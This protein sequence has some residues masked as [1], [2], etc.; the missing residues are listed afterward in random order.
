MRHLKRRATA[1]IGQLGEPDGAIGCDLDLNA[2]MAALRVLP[3]G[4][5]TERDLLTWIE[6]PLRGFFVFER[7]WGAYGNLSGR[8]IQRRSLISSGHDPEFLATCPA[9]F[10]LQSRSCFAWWVFHR[11]ALVLDTTG[12]QDET[13]ARVVATGCELD[14]IERFSLGV[15]AAHGVI[16]PF[17]STGTYF[18]FSG[19]PRTRPK[20]TLAALNLIAPVLHNL[21]LQTRQTTVST[22][23]LAA[24][25]DRQRELIDLAM[26]GLSDKDI[27]LRIGISHNT[28]GNH[29]SSIYAKLG[30]CKRGQLIALS[31]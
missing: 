24:L 11:K 21:Y 3:N 20:R 25:T 10:D 27:A 31:K 6:G 7:F 5:L 26:Q 14:D 18:S 1:D 30:V 23:G 13:G 15:V 4:P 17:A 28:V 16:D 12:G 19:V 9:N 29:L 8:L 2:W 22:L